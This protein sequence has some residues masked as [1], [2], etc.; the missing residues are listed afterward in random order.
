[1]EDTLYLNGVSTSKKRRQLVTNRTLVMV[2]SNGNPDR[3][4][5]VFLANQAVSGHL[6]ASFLIRIDPGLAV[7]ERYLSLVLRSSSIQERITESTAGST[8]LRNLSLE[9]LRGLQLA[10]PPLL[11]QR[12]IAAVLD[13][14]AGAIERT[15][16]VI[17]ATVRLRDALL[18][19]LLTRGVP[20]WHSAWKDV[21][22]PRDGP[23]VLGGGA[24]GGPNRGRSYERYLQAGV[25]IRGGICLIRIDDFVPG[26]LVNTG[27]FQRIRASEDERHRYAVREGD[28]LINRVNSLSHIGKTVLIRELGEPTLF[29]SNMMKLR[30]DSGVLPR[31]AEMVLLSHAARGHFVSRAKKAVQQA[32]I[33]QQDVVSFPLSLPPLSE[34]GA[35]TG[36]LDAVDAAVE[37]ARGERSGLLALQASASDA[38]LTGRVRV[39]IL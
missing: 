38:L 21:P 19:E 39:G 29:E 27:S 13:S 32:S 4:G 28:I 20:G 8:G 15:D 24:V 12:A 33:N 14:I 35:I 10:L 2:G 9:W 6:L 23:G 37:S 5:N 16:D 26:A 7:S 1:M 30:M 3:V 25:R 11:E 31:F 17:A 18:H 36:M 34:Q 22:G